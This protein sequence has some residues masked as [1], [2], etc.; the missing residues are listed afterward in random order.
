MKIA[1]RVLTYLLG[2]LLAL[3]AASPAFSKA[4]VVSRVQ[5]SVAPSQPTAGGTFVVSTQLF[6]TTGRPCITTV[7]ATV[8]GISQTRNNVLNDFEG[9]RIIQRATVMGD[10]VEGATQPQWQPAVAS[11]RLSA[12]DRHDQQLFNFLRDTGR[13]APESVG[14]SDLVPK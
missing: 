3:G 8:E 9:E 7:T 4:T 10:Q 11:G 1:S 5:T 6:G 13:I 14:Y 2:T 12:M